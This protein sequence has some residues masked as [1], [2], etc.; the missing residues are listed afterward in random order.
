M[1]WIMMSAIYVL[2]DKNGKILLQ[3][4]DKNTKR[5]PNYWGFFGGKVE[6]EESPEEAVKREAREELDI[7]LKDLKLFKEYEFKQ[8]KEKEFVFVDPLTVSLE[9]LRKQQKEGQGL[10]LFSFE[11]LRNLKTPPFERVIFEDLFGKKF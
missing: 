10:G 4:R 8:R 3:H 5:F 2:R 7:E 9:K 1:D 11:E 6:K